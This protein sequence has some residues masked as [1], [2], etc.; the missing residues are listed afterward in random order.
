MPY[1]MLLQRGS[2]GGTNQCLGRQKACS[3]TPGNSFG[4]DEFGD[5]LVIVTRHRSL[6]LGGSVQTARWRG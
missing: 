2:V 4:A 5:R 6:T 3:R 1:R